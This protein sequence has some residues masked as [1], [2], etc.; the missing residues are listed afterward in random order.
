M[1]EERADVIV[2]GGGGGSGLAAASGAA[3][4]DGNTIPGTK[5]MYLAVRHPSLSPEA[6]VTRWRTHGA[7]AMSF[8]ARQQWENVT[9]YVQCDALRDHGL[10]GIAPDFDGIGMISF[11]DAE[12]R[13]RHVGNADARAVLEA[14]E[15]DT[16][17]MR[18]NRRGF[19]AAE[20]VL[21]ARSDPE[22]ALVRVIRRSR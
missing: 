11:R 7:L 1:N 6:F 13:K 8:M 5:R 4:A 20:M 10:E 21:I 18:V 2:L 19:V 15:D 22:V 12:A 9:R 16:F 3:R 14:D 17:A